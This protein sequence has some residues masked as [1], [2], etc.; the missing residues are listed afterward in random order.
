MLDQMLKSLMDA[1]KR[2]ASNWTQGRHF[3]EILASEEEGCPPQRWMTHCCWMGG[4][5][6]SAYQL[7]VSTLDLSGTEQPISLQ[8]GS[9]RHCKLSALGAMQGLHLKQV[10]FSCRVHK[11]HHASACSAACV[12]A[13][14]GLSAALTCS[15]SS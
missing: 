8:Q 14:Y 11:P 12:S 7:I 6:T 13:W 9:G 2:K 3:Q 4:L 5:R 1:A 15:M 10:P